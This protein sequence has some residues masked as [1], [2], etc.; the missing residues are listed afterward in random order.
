MNYSKVKLSLRTALFLLAAF[1][2]AMAR[3]AGADDPADSLARGNTA[4]QADDYA[5]AYRL[6]DRVF[7]N[8]NAQF[9]LRRA[10]YYRREQC[11]DEN[12]TAVERRLL[13]GEPERA[14]ECLEQAAPFAARGSVERAQ[15][16]LW[17]AKILRAHP[18][19][20]GEVCRRLKTRLGAGVGDSSEDVLNDMLA[21]A[22]PFAPFA[23]RSEALYLLFKWAGERGDAKAAAAALQRLRAE[24]AP[25]PFWVWRADADNWADYN[26]GPGSRPDFDSIMAQAGRPRATV[27]RSAGWPARTTATNLAALAAALEQLRQMPASEREGRIVFVPGGCDLDL[28]GSFLEIPAGVILAGDRGIDASARGN[29]FAVQPFRPRRRLHYLAVACPADRI[30]TAGRARS[31]LQCFCIAGA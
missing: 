2:A 22:D 14:A 15:L 5:A 27:N 1:Y 9:V 3:A 26:Y 18:Q 21:D 25:H 19:N 16:A 12:L 10:A 4:F 8:T 17:C 28:R 13:A 11:V 29:D 7:Q 30:P 6:Y 31:G 23:E 24:P 20:D